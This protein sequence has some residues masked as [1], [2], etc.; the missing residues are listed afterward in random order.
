[1]KILAPFDK[2]EEVSALVQAG[3]DELYCGVN[4][5]RWNGKNIFPNARH[6]IYGNLRSFHELEK[7]LAITKKNGIP[8]FLCAND[9]LTK[10]AFQYLLQDICQAIDLGIDGIIIADIS[11]IPLIKR[12]DPHCKIILSCLNPCFSSQSV[13]FYRDL[14][15]G[16]VILP[17]NQLTLEEIERIVSN[18]KHLDIELEVFINNVVCRNIPGNCLYNDLDVFDS[19]FNSTIQFIYKNMRLI[20]RLIPTPIRDMLGRYLFASQ[21]HP[22]PCRERCVADIFKKT[23]NGLQKVNIQQTYTLDRDFAQ[24]FCNMCGVY[25]LNRFGITSG[26]IAGRGFPTRM[27]VNDVV[28]THAFLDEMKH[29]VIDE[30]NF[31]QRGRILYRQTFGKD[32]QNAECHY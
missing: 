1:M 6:I 16:R 18:T 23:E 21:L 3:A 5:E 25:F 14:G 29:S 32:C 31:S 9:Y 15:I 27:K 22:S 4:T 7:S 17:I 30:H 24:V 11:I 12:A 19:Q 13:E 28:F 8:I 2:V 20:G 26:K 10:G